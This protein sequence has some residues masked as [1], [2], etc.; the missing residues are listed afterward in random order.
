[1]KLKL[2]EKIDGYELYAEYTKLWIG[3]T[4]IDANRNTYLAA[5]G[6]M[7][8][9]LTP[10]RKFVDWGKVDW[11]VLVE[12]RDDGYMRELKNMHRP[13]CIT[14]IWQAHTI[15]DK[16]PVDPEAFKV[17]VRYVAGGNVYTSTAKGVNWAAVTQYKAY[18][19][20]GYEYK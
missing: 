2:Q 8:I 3:D 11:S 13:R 18:L 14:D 20:D 15:G 9:T 5:S 12:P 10:E 7:G 4:G 1:M 19:A 6:H 17:G 16:C